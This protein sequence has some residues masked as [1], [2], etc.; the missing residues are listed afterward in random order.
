MNISQTRIAASGLALLLSIAAQAQDAPALPAPQPVGIIGAAAGTGPM[1]AVA[2]SDASMRQNTLYH[3]ARLPRQALPLVLWAE[4][5]CADNGLMYGSFLREIA[6]HGYFIVAAGYPRAER[7]V[8][9]TPTPAPAAPV[10]ATGATRP[11]PPA[12]LE[13]DATSTDQLQQAIDWARTRNADPRSPLYRHIDLQHIAVMGHSCGGLQT[14]LIAADPRIR[15]AVVF[16]SGVLNQRRGGKSVSMETPKEQLLKLHSPVAYINGGPT[17][18]AYL[19]AA[20]DFARLEHVPVFFAENGV[21]HGG[22]YWTAPN[23]GDYAQ[24]AVAWLDWQLKRDA[25]AAKMFR[26]TDCGLCTRAGWKVQKKHID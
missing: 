7:T 10:S 4:G 21:G 3:P 26:G 6:S 2:E 1:P 20:D 17:D 16:N 23:G 8:A 14:V 13:A 9:P 12:A 22:T 24:V 15:T 19:N 25:Q 5:G 11:T 18:V